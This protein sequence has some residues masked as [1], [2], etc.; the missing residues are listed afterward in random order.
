M[1]VVFESLVF[2]VVIQCFRLSTISIQWLVDIVVNEGRS[3]Y[4][5]PFGFSFIKRT[6]YFHSIF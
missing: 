6:F 2:A 1:D 5:T 3:L 4:S